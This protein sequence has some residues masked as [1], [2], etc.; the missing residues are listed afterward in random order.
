MKPELPNDPDKLFNRAL[1]EW[2][3]K[4]PLP[5]RFGERVWQ[6]IAREE[7]HAPAGFS[8]LLSNWIAQALARPALAVSYVTV[9]LM[10]GLLAG[11]WHAQTE[12]ARTLESL[13]ARYV[14]M[15]NPYEAHGMNR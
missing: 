4:E 13:S 5:P 7:A 3:I 9:L 11:Y 6:R 8:A 1:R 15:I 2:E 12:K 10:A 14:Q